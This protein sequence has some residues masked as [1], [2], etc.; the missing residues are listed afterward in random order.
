[1][2][3]TEKLC[4]TLSIPHNAFFIR[5]VEDFTPYLCSNYE[6]GRQINPNSLEN[7]GHILCEAEE[8]YKHMIEELTNE[9]Q[10]IESFRKSFYSNT[11]N[12]NEETS[13]PS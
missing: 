2:I 10:K 7:E 8:L 3:N 9:L 6:A 12:T 1:M 4:K 11:D 5:F 13:D